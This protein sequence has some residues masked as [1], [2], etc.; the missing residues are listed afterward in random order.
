M[1]GKDRRASRR[2]MGRSGPFQH[3]AL[4]QFLAFSILALLIWA[5]AALDFPSLF[6]RLPPARLGWY[7]A[8]VLTAGVIVVGFIT[9]AHS[10][11]QHKRVLRG[12]IRVCSYCRRVQVD[13]E[14]WRKMEEYVEDRTLAEFTHGVCPDCY[15]RVMKEMD[16]SSGDGA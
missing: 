4:W 11:L 5:D 2:P 1:T 6:F 7:R 9:I 3:I 14:A 16:R 10:Y 8:C 15:E 13:Q 12:L